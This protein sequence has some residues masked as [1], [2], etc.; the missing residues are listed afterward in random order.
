MQPRLIPS[1]VTGI[2]LYVPANHVLM[3]LTCL[4]YFLRSL[5]PTIFRPRPAPTFHFN[6]ELKV[7]TLLFIT[8][9]FLFYFGVKLISKQIPET[10]FLLP[11]THMVLNNRE[12]A[13]FF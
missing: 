9:T 11:G 10:V 5:L 6:S 1:Y 12:L 2:S 8:Y 3:C 13:L 4:L 7:I